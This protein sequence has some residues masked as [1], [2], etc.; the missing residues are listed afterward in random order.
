LTNAYAGL[1]SLLAKDQ[2]A[3][4]QSPPSSTNNVR[5]YLE[6]LDWDKT[7]PRRAA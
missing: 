7:P 1:F 5:D 2:Y 3:V 6:T 4:G